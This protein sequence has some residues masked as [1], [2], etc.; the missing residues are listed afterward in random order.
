MY[1]PAQLVGQVLFYAS[2]AAGIGSFANA[3]VYRHSDPALALVRLTFQ[4]AGEH[5]RECQRLSPAEIARLAPNMRRP[6]ACA[7]ERVD[8]VLEFDLDGQTV[9]SARLPPTGLAKDGPAT[10][11]AS[12][13]V[14]PGRHSI[15][16]RMRDS[17]RTE[18]F[19]HVNQQVVELARRQVVVIDFS[20]AEGGFK[21]LL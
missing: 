2:F 3:P 17:R 14:V 18:G 13:P 8:L 5:V 9:Y 19:D 11:Y 16:A 15:T 20:K 4:H 1:K 7:R 12:F 21:F 6:L 10:V